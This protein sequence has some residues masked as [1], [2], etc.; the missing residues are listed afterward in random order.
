MR[1]L[2]AAILMTTL[3]VS[4][5]ALAAEGKHYSDPAAAA[6]VCKSP[7]VWVNPNSGVYHLQGSR[8]YGTTKDGFYMCQKAAEA[9]GNRQAEGH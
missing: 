3:L 4:P 9:A 2:V 6:K 8:Y 1:R 5:A 7:V